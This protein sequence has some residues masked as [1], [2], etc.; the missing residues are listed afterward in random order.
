M[1]GIELPDADAESAEADS[2][3]DP[4]APT[5]MTW[6]D[7]FLDEALDNMRVI[8]AALKAAEAEGFQYPAGVQ[9]Q[10]DDNM[11]ALKAVAA[12]S[13]ISVSQ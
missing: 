2:E 3:A 4:L 13:G 8:Q 1:L 9:A 6:H 11:D 7:Y 10:Y 5:G 12:A